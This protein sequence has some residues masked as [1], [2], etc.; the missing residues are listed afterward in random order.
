MVDTLGNGAA[1]GM[2][3]PAGYE[4][5]PLPKTTRRELLPSTWVNRTLRLSYVGAGGIGVESSGTLLDLTVTGPIF[6]LD[7]GKILIAWERLVLLELVN[8]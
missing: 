1:T 2:T 8:D 5:K 4:D 7:G 3:T 6:N